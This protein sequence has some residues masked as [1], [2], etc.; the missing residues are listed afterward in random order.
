LE[1]SDRVLT[2]AGLKHDDTEPVATEAEAFSEADD[3]PIELD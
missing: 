2:A 3:A 1:I